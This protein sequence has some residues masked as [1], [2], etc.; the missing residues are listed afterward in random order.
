MTTEYLNIRTINCHS[1]SLLNKN[2]TRTYPG[3]NQQEAGYWP[4]HLG[5]E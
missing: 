5:H 3:S 1:L 4:P 2:S